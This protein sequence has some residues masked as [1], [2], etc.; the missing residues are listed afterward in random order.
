MKT[1]LKLMAGTLFICM[2]LCSCEKDELETQELT[3]DIMLKTFNNGMI[4]SYSNEAVLKWNAALAVIDNSRPPAAEAK[5]Y[6]MVTLAMHDALN[7]VVPKYETY[8]LDNSSV[9]ASHVSKKN[10]AQIADAAVAQ[11]AHD[12]LI[13]LHPP[14]TASTNN[15]LS[16]SLEA[17]T[18]LELKLL[19]INIGQNAAAAVLAK[20]QNDIVFGFSAYNEGTEPGTHQ[21]NYLPWINANPPA[22]PA[23]AVYGANLGQL[24]PFGMET[25]NQFRARPPYAINSPE[26]LADYDEVKL[27]GCASCPD[28]T[29]EQSE[30]GAFWVENLS[31]S[32][33]RIGRALAIEKNL[34]GWETAR[35]LAITQMA[36]IDAHISSMEAKYHYKLWRPITA[37]TSGDTDGNTSTI[38]NPSWISVYR[39]PPTPD[40]PSTHS[41]C[42]G[43]AAEV[44]KLFFGTDTM[45]QSII[46]PYT[47]PN[48]ERNL[49]NFSQ[50]ADEVSVSRIYIGY[51]FRN[52]VE[53]GAIEGRRLGKY[54]FVN[55][56]RELRPNL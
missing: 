45:P 14:S 33:N 43:A 36:Q 19:G 12:V 34:N 55:N 51:H 10:I 3:D 47:L 6:A 35:L 24:T 22:W 17:I 21:S 32:M 39:T 29:S 46:S 50:I 27:L 40:Y 53:Q 54:V 1:N 9:D 42:G 56:L 16:A 52:A 7:N 30:I 18:N 44:F 15:L 11:A 20:R 5:I 31:S 48:I 23:N 13:V 28:R 4:K 41:E 37:I 49:Y 8:A 2:M 26:Y 38:G 25:S